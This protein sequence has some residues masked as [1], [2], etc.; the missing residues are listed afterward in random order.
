MNYHIFLCFYLFYFVKSI[1][2]NKYSKF[3]KNK[4]IYHVFNDVIKQDLKNPIIFNGIK[5]PLKKDFFKILSELNDIPFKEYTFDYFMMEHPHVNNKNSILYVNDFL[6]GHGRILN[7]YEENILLNLNKNNNLIVFQ[8]DDIN[9]IPFK[10]TNII[11]HFPI[12]NFPEIKKKE[13]IQYIYDIITLNKYIDD[14][15]IL[16]WIKYDIENLDLEKLNILLYEI[17]NISKNILDSNNLDS[18]DL[19]DNI[20][21]IISSLQ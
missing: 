1:T 12:I 9:L 8:S 13:I 10:D 5:S 3:L 19:Y 6:V 20:N 16:N 17:N 15:Y 2:I 4:S 11:R 21:K 18:N 14:L 7:H